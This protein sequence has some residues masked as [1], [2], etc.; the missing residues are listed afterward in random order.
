VHIQTVQFLACSPKFQNWYSQNRTG[1][2]ARSG[3]EVT[4]PP[5]E[6]QV[7]ANWK[8]QLVATKAIGKQLSAKKE[9]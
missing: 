7:L 6:A 9:I 1:R 4:I 8:L 2:T 5:R 3:L